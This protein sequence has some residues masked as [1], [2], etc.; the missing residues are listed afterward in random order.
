MSAICLILI[1]N[2]V[3]S[4]MDED[5]LMLLRSWNLTEAS[6]KKLAGKLHLNVDSLF[7]DFGSY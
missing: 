3:V 1:I 7:S 4:D 5:A 6:I 2:R